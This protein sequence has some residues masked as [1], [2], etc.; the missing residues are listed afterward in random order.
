MYCTCISYIP[1]INPKHISAIGS[2][3]G[4]IMNFL[5]TLIEVFVCIKILQW[6]DLL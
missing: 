4:F 1:M 3:I 2:I 5:F 6:M